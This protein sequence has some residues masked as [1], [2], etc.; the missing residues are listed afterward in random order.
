MAEEGP[1][2]MDIAASID[3]EGDSNVHQRA[4]AT[5]STSG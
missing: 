2:V 4:E 1:E 3:R 5:E